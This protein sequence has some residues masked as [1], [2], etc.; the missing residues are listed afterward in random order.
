MTGTVAIVLTAVARGATR[1]PEGGA[2]PRTARRPTWVVPVIAAATLRRVST[3]YASNGYS[4]VDD[5][6]DGGARSGKDGV[7]RDIK[8]VRKDVVE[9]GGIFGVIQS[10]R[11]HA[12]GA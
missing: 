1:A 2:N 10:A 6:L 5:G 7:A 4:S 3:V 11:G 9:E 12:T 8:R